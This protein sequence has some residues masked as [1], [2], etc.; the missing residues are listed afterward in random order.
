MSA[1]D[2]FVSLGVLFAAVLL[3]ALVFWCVD[4]A[5]AWSQE[6]RW[7]RQEDFL[8]RTLHSASWWFSEDEPTRQLVADLA[9]RSVSDARERWRKARQATI[10]VE[11]KGPKIVG[12]LHVTAQKPESDATGPKEAQRSNIGPPHSHK[13]RV[14]TKDEVRAM[15]CPLPP[16]DDKDLAACSRRGEI[17]WRGPEA[18]AFGRAVKAAQ[19]HLRRT[20]GALCPAPESDDDL[21]C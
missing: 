13:V 21:E 3:A 6:R 10:R 2:F 18:D 8:R 20:P 16:E 9:D 14:L 17:A 15:D 5:R 7:D 11:W 4:K 19:E 12:K 1:V